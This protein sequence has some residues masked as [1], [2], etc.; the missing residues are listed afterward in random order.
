MTAIINCLRRALSG[1]LSGGVTAQIKPGLTLALCAAVI[2]LALYAGWARAGR[3][4]L[5]GELAQSRARAAGLTRELTLNHQ[6]LA[7]REAERERLAAENAELHHQINEVYAN[8][9]QAR[10]WADTL[11][12]NAVVDRLRP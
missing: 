12:P 6:A 8:D 9:S 5:A 7:R 4:R 3:D 2:G 1:R 10:L 11:C